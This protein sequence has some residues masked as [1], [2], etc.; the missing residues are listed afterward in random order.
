VLDA[1]L[2]AKTN[3]TPSLRRRTLGTRTLSTTD[4]SLNAP[5]IGFLVDWLLIELA[6]TVIYLV[7]HRVSAQLAQLVSNAMLRLRQQQIQAVLAVLVG[8]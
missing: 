2:C 3:L 8:D 7:R 1:G 5:K 4:Q 6:N